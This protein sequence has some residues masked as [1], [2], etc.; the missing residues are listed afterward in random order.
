MCGKY[1]ECFQKYLN[2]FFWTKIVGQ[3]SAGCHV[4]Q[5]IEIWKN[6]F[7][8]NSIKQL[9]IKVFKMVTR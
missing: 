5:V 3:K 6:D 2:A 1:I 4:Y 8:M 9:L 7:G